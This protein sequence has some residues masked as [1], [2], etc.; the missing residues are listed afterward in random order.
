MLILTDVDKFI[1]NE[2]LKEIGKK[3]DVKVVLQKVEGTVL[4]LN[5]KAM[6]ELEKFAFRKIEILNGNPF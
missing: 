4:G 6:K 5:K 2:A 3:E 1:F